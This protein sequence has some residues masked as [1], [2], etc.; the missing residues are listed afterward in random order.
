MRILLLFAIGMISVTTAMAQ[1]V[2]MN[3][4]AVTTRHHPVTFT[5]QDTAYLLTGTT[6]QSSPG[7]TSSFYRYDEASD[8]WVNL[9]DFPGG[10]RSYAYAATYDGKAYFG[11][12]TND[13]NTFYNDL[14]EYD[15]VSKEWTELASCDCS[16]RSHPAFVAQAGRI[17]V[18]LGNGPFDRNDWWSYDIAADEWSQMPDLPGQPRHHPFHFAAGDHVY[19]GMGHNGGT[20][21]ADWYQFDPATDSWTQMEDHPGGPRVAGQEFSYDGSGYVISGDGS[22]H[23]NLED[24]EFWKYLHETDEWERL[25]DHPGNAPDGRVGR[26]APGAFVVNDHLYFFGGVNRGGGFL[27]GDTWRY[28][29]RTSVSAENPERELVSM[30]VFPNPTR[31]E[32]RVKGKAVQA[33]DKYQIYN[34]QGVLVQ[35]DRLNAGEVLRLNGELSSGLYFLRIGQQTTTFFIAR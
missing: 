18:G 29:L 17:F 31:S 14:W 21:L 12:G 11:F 32:I 3:G 35:E 5:L 33:Q 8:Q 19:A 4:S 26:W 6:A 25:P 1:W 10:A 34:Q 13:S 27:F 28:D 2:E 7:G 16:G 15:P 24:G 20:F 30:E 23:E 9:G 22:Q